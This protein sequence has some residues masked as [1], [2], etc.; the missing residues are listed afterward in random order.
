MKKK[1]TMGEE[2]TFVV[3]VE[4]KISN[5]ATANAEH[6]TALP[7]WRYTDTGASCSP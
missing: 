2:S 4:M 3:A 5:S 6:G 7:C 1:T